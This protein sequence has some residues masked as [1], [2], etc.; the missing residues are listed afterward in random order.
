MEPPGKPARFT[1]PGR[2]FHDLRR[3]AVRRF[4]QAGITRGVAMKLTGHKTES[5]YRRYAIVSDRDLRAA[6][7]TLS[8]G[9]YGHDS[10]HS[11][12]QAAR[13]V[14]PLAGG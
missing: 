4:E 3:S 9:A 13:N 8:S 10:G 14:Y 12:P 6:A 11:Q 7:A 5:V 2:L 1:V